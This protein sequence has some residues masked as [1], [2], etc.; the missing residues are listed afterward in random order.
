MMVSMKM[1]AEERG[2][3]T[4]PAAPDSPYP[5]GL[6]IALNDDDMQKLGMSECPDVGYVMQ[7][8]ALVTV[9]RCSS[10][11]EQGGDAENSMSLQI[12]DMQ[13]DAPMMDNAA[14]AEKLYGA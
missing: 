2:E 9:T 5:Y 12:T 10:S 6:Q 3:G 13:L 1:S 4:A 14:R 7:M 11:Q 8:T